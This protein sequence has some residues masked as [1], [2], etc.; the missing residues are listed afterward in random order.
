M[1][2]DLWR[3]FQDL[4]KILWRYWSL[5]IFVTEVF[6]DLWGSWKILWPFSPGIATLISLIY[7]VMRLFFYLFIYFCSEEK[8]GWSHGFKEDWPC[9][10]KQVVLNF[11]WMYDCLKVGKDSLLILLSLLFWYPPLHPEGLNFVCLIL[12]LVKL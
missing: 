9:L 11:L 1:S 5:K 2:E 10:N 8:K 6:K 7:C 3:S 4:W 12:I